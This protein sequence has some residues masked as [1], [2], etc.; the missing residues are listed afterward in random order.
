M[1]RQ[2]GIKVALPAH[3]FWL[4][5]AGTCPCSKQNWEGTQGPPSGVGL[6]SESHRD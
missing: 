6:L 5:P 4:R 1:T 2:M 3:S